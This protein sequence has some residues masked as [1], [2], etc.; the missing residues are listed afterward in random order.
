MTADIDLMYR[1]VLV[2]EEDRKYQKKKNVWRNNVKDP[3]MLY[4]LNT[5]TCGKRTFSRDPYD[6]VQLPSNKFDFTQVITNRS[7]LTH[8]AKFFD[9]LGLPAPVIF[10]AKL[11]MQL[12]NLVNTIFNIR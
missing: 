11:F 7:I 4:Q 5:V 6:T 1:Q 8:I 12:L 9:P 3:V 2:K 10:R